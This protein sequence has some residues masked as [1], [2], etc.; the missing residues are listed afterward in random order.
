MNYRLRSLRSLNKTKYAT[1]RIKMS[2]CQKVSWSRI[3]AGAMAP[4][5]QKAICHISSI[6]QKNPLANRE[7]ISFYLFTFLPL[8]RSISHTRRSRNRREEGREGGYY[9]LHRYLNDTL[10]HLHTDCLMSHRSLRS[11]RL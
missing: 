3:R 4:T 8:K 1:A 10:F 5:G 2:P 6:N 9:Y 11:H 7:G